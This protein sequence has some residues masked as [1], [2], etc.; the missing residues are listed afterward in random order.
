MLGH[1]IHDPCIVPVLRAWPP[2]ADSLSASALAGPPGIPGMPGQNGM[3]G[4]PGEHLQHENWSQR[5][6][7]APENA[8]AESPCELK[9]LASC[10]CTCEELPRGY[11]FTTCCDAILDSILQDLIT[12]SSFLPI[13]HSI[14]REGASSRQLFA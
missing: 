6:G 11:I 7:R 10:S 2:L 12:R 9:V 13:A 14:I 1:S 8:R 5:E 3:H 4:P